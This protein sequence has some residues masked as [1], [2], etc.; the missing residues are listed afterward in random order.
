MVDLF[1]EPPMPFAQLWSRAVTMNLRS[2]PIRVAPIDD[3]IAL[4]RQA[5]RPPGSSSGAH[6]HSASTNGWP[7]WSR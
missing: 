3:V 4:K 5:G 6:W 7:G 1:L 2:V